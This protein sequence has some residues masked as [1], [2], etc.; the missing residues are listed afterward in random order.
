MS[1]ASRSAH[2]LVIALARVDA[3]D[4]DSQLQNAIQHGVERRPVARRRRQTRLEQPAQRTVHR[5]HLGR[6]VAVVEQ[7]GDLRRVARRVKRHQALRM[8]Q[9]RQRRTHGVHGVARVARG[10]VVTARRAAQHAVAPGAVRIIDSDSARRQRRRAK[11]VH[12]ASHV[13]Q[14]RAPIGLAA[15]GVHDRTQSAVHQQSVSICVQKRRST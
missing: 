14:H 11:V 4:L 6:R 3:L 2:R 8:E 10:K 9:L 12:H 1:A 13:Q 15:V 7:V 5:V